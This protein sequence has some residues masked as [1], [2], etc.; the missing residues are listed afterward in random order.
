MFEP[1]TTQRL[2]VRN[3]QDTDRELFHRINSDDQVMRYFPFRRTR[4]QSDVLMDSLA[5]RIDR[6]GIG[7]T[8]LTLRDTGEPIGFCGLAYT[9]LAPIFA[10]G[11][12]EIG[13]RLAPEFWRKGYATEAALAWLYRGFVDR[14]LSQIVSFAVQQ[15]T[16]SLAIMDR[17]G[18]LA[19]PAS[20]FDHPK[21][22]D[23]HQHLKKHL[24]YR[25]SRDQWFE[26][27]E[28]RAT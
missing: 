5:T 22:P 28:Q 14:D 2:I 6:D 19:D 27:E 23:S 16:P 17:I 18:M 10:N 11:S 7:F 9:D 26:A 21:V 1:F 3:W 20:T 8:A 13:W 24:V 12:V 4:Q 15:N 25:L